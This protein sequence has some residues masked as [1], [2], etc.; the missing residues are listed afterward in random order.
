MKL[1]SAKLTILLMAVSGA[2]ALVGIAVFLIVPTLTDVRG[3]RQSILTAQAELEA[4]YTNRKNLLASQTKVLETRETMKLL[5]TQ[6]VPAGH[7][8]DFIT[9]VE[10]LAAENGV[11]ER[12]QLSNAEK[13]VAPELE[14]RFD[15]T[16]TGMFHESLQTLIDLEKRPTLM[17]IESMTVRPGGSSDGPPVLSI[18][19]HGSIAVPPK[20]LL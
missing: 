10:A 3:L 2:I 13:P 9:A 15:L 17:V 16:L 11:T 4:Q 5:S 20:G 14:K 18:D 1:K 12:L 7:E 19:V 6:F 8:L